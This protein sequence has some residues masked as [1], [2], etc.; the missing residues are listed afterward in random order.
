MG[1]GGAARS[2]QLCKIWRQ[3]LD[4]LGQL[5]GAALCALRVAGGW[6]SAAVQPPSTDFHFSAT[7][8]L[9]DAVRANSIFYHSNEAICRD[10]RQ[11]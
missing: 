3:H 6:D 4:E 1:E 11:A 8:C 2:Q 5:F 7:H 9:L 10:I